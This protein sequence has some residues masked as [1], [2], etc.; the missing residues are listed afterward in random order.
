[1]KKSNRFLNAW[2]DTNLELLNI[3]DF[4]IEKNEYIQ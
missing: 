4:K 2:N 1:M 3:I